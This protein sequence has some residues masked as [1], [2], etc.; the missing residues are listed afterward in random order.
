M[1]VF[2]HRAGLLGLV[3][4]IASLAGCSGDAR[5]FE[6]AVEVRDLGLARLE[7][8]PPENTQLPLFV[9]HGER[10]EFALE[11]FDADGGS[12]EVSGVD[13]AWRV[14]DPALASIDDDGTFVARA[15]GN[16]RVDVV[17][18]DIT[19]SA[20]P[21][22]VRQAALASVSSIEGPARLDPCVPERYF[23]IGRY[24]DEAGS[25]RLL[26]DV[27][28]SVAGGAGR[29]EPVEGGS[30]DFSASR[31]GSVELVAAATIDGQP[32]LGRPIEIGATLQG[33]SIDPD[34][35]AADVGETVDLSAIGEFDD[36]DGGTRT[37]EVTDG[38]DWAVTDG[39]AFASV[40]DEAPTRGRVSADAEGTAQVRASCGDAEATVRF[41]ANAPNESADDDDDGFAFQGDVDGDGI[42]N[43]GLGDSPITLRISRGETYDGTEDVTSSA[44]F[45]VVGGDTGIASFGTE[46]GQQNVLFLLGTGDVVVQAVVDDR[47]ARLVVNVFN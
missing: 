2:V 12:V 11:G 37:R 38:V 6:E 20:F 18:A 40:S 3:L 36:G 30:V 4:A 14:S 41:D 15:D 45:S 7:I 17:I 44:D 9:N 21:L 8:V 23:A 43:V 24:N 19:A 5:P 29:V 10:V 13:R 39:T 1:S 33:L 47:A 28:W 42:L 35:A 26:R 16:V 32:R 27:S 34:I 22:T 46:L 25:A 31:P